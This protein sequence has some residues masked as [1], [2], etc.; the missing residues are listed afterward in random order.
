[1][2]FGARHSLGTGRVRSRFLLIILC[3][4]ALSLF[5]CSG[6]GEVKHPGP[7]YGKVVKKWTRSAGIYRG[8]DSQLF[9]HATYRGLEIRD[10]YVREYAERYQLDEYQRAKLLTDEQEGYERSEEL[11][12]G[13]HTQE[14]KWNDLHRSD[15]IWRLYLKNDRG[16]RVRPLEVRRVD[17][18]SP[19]IKAFYPR[20]DKWSKGYVVTF[21]KYSETGTEPIVSDETRKIHLVITGVLG[22]TEITWKLKKR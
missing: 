18:E 10:A 11:F 4:S 17:A 6:R 2:I 13:V 16:E 7:P 22:E 19:L 20:L 8:M 9:V 3:L 14:D 15:S 21:P 12:L 5:S 1:M